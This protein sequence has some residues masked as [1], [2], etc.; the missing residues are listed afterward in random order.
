LPSA[1][2]KLV[3]IGGL[4]PSGGAGLAR[5]FSTAEALGAGVVL[6]GTAWTDQSR[7]G[8]RGFEPR[9][10]ER[11][12]DAVGRALEGADAVKIGM[13]ATASLAEALLEAL[14]G[15]SGPVVL[16][17][18]LGATSGGG[19]F[20]GQPRQLLPLVRRATLTTPNLAEATALTG[21]PVTN[22]EEARVAG[23]ILVDAGAPAVLVKG[24]HLAG[25]A[26]D[27]LVTAAAEE[28]FTAERLPGP[29]PRGTGCA[30]ATALAIE[31][32][33]GRSLPA[34]V[35]AA[36]RWLHDRIRDARF[37]GGERHL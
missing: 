36:K 22:L 32:G 9:A 8:V 2:V 28:A 29:S 35:A 37:V 1:P 17:P 24:G 10:P 31:L 23:R 13:V 14:E 34:A 18:V 33:R 11:L 20:T 7:H 25:A 27:L 12:A 15:F 4:D 6:V 26:T 30:L 3:A 21:L 5:D 19:L 16:D